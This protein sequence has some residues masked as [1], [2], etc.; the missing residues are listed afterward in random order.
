MY[1]GALHNPMIN[2]NIRTSTRFLFLVFNYFSC[3]YLFIVDIV[4]TRR[5]VDGLIYL[6][7][8]TEGELGLFAEAAQC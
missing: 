2:I 5:T 6:S 7:F 3:F 4:N 1:L 8:P